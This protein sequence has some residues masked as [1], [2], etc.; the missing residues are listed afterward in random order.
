M[1]QR[2]S[3][4]LFPVVVVAL[5]GTGVWGY[6]E[7]Q[8]K[9]SIL[10]KAEN[11]Y[12]RA[13]HDLSYYMDQLNTELGKAMAVNSSSEEFQK[14]KLIQVWR[15]TSEAQNQINQLPLA[16]L[17]FNKTEEFLDRIA[18]FTYRASLRDLTKSPLSKEEQG[19]LKELHKRSKE[20]STELRS[21][22]TKALKDHLRWMDVE[23]ALASDDK[24]VDNAII[25]GF[26]TVDNK[27]S[28]Y[29]E[30]QWGPSVQSLYEN[31]TAEMIKGKPATKQ[32]ISKKAAEFLGGRR[33]AKIKV[34]ENGKGTEYSSYSVIAEFGDGNTLNM[35]YSKNG[36]HLLWFMNPREVKNSKLT[37]S[38]ASKRAEQFLGEHKYGQAVPVNY[39]EYNNVS[40]VT[41]AATEDGII[42][43]PR[44]VTVKVAM[45]NGE[46]LGIQAHDFVY[47][48]EQKPK[49][50]PK[51]T[52]DEAAKLLSPSFER[53]R[54]AKAYIK[55]DLDEKVL[56]YEFTGR[57]NGEFFRIF[58]NTETGEEEKVETIQP[59]EAAFKRKG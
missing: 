21:I 43:Y 47:E 9:N 56:C 29:S 53:S 10:I 50:K 8:E 20:L 26:K 30:V 22:Q 49:Q 14:R 54:S 46:I 1:Y 24:K 7:H 5:I 41:F 28:E 59:V 37:P 35:D 38:Q 42:N 51:M 36:G 15:M 55:N 44:K 11:Q 40:S 31:R 52:M 16:L 4:V 33:Q 12:Q 32:E 18:N 6:Q 17:P 57:I 39:D 2:L 13:F 19:T 34:T 23:L 45:D 27:V 48:E 25:D 3:A 58:L